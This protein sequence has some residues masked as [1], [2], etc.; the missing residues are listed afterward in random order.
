MACTDASAPFCG[1]LFNTLAD[2]KVVNHPVCVATATSI[3]VEAT[4]RIDSSIQTPVSSTGTR[5]SSSITD[6]V[7]NSIT[8]RTTS[9]SLAAG[10]NMGSN[11]GATTTR[12]TGGAAIQTAKAIAGVVA[13]GIFGGI[14]LFL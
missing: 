4:A 10:V 2:G 13:G 3:E 6:Q 7:Q 8:T 14:A 1:N 9:P 12:S 5:R 11:S